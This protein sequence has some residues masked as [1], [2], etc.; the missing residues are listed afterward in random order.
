MNRRPISLTTFAVHENKNASEKQGECCNT[1]LFP[2]NLYDSEILMGQLQANRFEVERE[3]KTDDAAIV[4][5]N[6]CGFIDNAKQES[7]DTILRYV[8]AKD[9]G[10]VEKRL[11]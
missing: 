5:I 10:A 6:T 8:D 11:S 7:I 1:R 9:A 2:K 3:S 4:I